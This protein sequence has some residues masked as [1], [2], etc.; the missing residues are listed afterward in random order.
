M[1]VPSIIASLFS[2]SELD[3]FGRLL[4]ENVHNCVLLGWSLYFYSHKMAS[5]RLL[6]DP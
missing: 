3:T 5:A 1:R 6:I 2:V 4:E